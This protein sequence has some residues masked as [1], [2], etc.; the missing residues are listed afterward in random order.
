MTTKYILL[1]KEL[2]D[3]SCRTFLSILTFLASP[4][5][6][7]DRSKSS[8]HGFQTRRI[9]LHTRHRSQTEPLTSCHRRLKVGISSASRV[10]QD[11]LP[12]PTFDL[13]VANVTKRQRGIK[14]LHLWHI[15][16]TVTNP[17]LSDQADSS[18]SSQHES[19]P[20]SKNRS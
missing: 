19:R 13:T 12:Q 6:I 20:D 5:S 17:T 11:A 15:C 7:F 8:H 18:G 16:R 3:A 10:R 4:Q 14:I 1:R 9:H 2:P